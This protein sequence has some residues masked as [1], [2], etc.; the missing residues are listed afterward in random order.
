MKHIACLLFLV[1]FC[2]FRDTTLQSPTRGDW[3]A[4]VGT[5]DDIVGGREGQ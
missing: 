2:T 1:G 3:V 5:Y 4:W